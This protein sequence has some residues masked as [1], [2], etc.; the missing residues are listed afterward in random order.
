MGRSAVIIGVLSSLSLFSVFSRGRVEL[1]DV[2]LWSWREEC[3]SGRC[4]TGIN[5]TS[6]GAGNMSFRP[7]TAMESNALRLV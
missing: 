3:W 7:L 2:C 5:G 1:G 6:L 4:V